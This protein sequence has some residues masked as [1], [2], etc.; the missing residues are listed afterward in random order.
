MNNTAKAIEIKFSSP[1]ATV[2]KQAVQ[3]SPMTRVNKQA[4][5][6]L[7]ERRAM[8]SSPATRSAEIKPTSP[9]LSRRVSNSS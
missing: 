1:M 8:A 3:I 5:T 2:A 4:A 7:A 6:N 9:M